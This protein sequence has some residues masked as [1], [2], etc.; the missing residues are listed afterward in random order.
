MIY[1]MAIIAKEHVSDDDVSTL[2]GL[3]KE[4]LGQ[5]ESE[6]LIED[7]WG[8][9]TFAQ[10][11]ANNSVRGHYLYYIFKSENSATNAELVRRLKINESVTKQLIVNL[12]S[13][14][15][16]DKIVKSYKSP[17]SKK[18][19]GSVTDDTA[20]IDLDKDR[21]GF[22]RRKHCWFS[23]RKIKADWKDPN[24]YGWLV[25]E[26]G[27]ISPARVSGVSCKHQR[28]VTTA[29]K[30]ARQLSMISHL[31]RRTLQ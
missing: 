4:V 3:I 5:Y 25:N 27:K 19:N 23:A 30:R 18:Y 28:F 29:I 17:Y 20:D 13:D 21:R 16:L 14:A 2:N 8:K 31:S 12:G 7:D 9:R 26:F 24:T 1:E 15:E 6:L 11:A 10:P 22:S